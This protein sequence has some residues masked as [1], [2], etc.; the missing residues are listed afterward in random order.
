V[1]RN[2]QITIAATSIS[3]VIIVIG[4]YSISLEQ[5]EKM[6]YLPKA[7][8][9]RM[10]TEESN[11]VVIG[12]EKSYPDLCI[13]KGEITLTCENIMERSFNVTH[14]DPN[15]LDPDGNGIGCE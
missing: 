4:Y 10:T 3:L 15:N 14:D 6:S 1:N 8:I 12:C 9:Q 5:Q 11:S 13:P 7:V 2:I